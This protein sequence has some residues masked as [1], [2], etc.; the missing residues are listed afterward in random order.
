MYATKVCIR[1]VN[2]ECSFSRNHNTIKVKKKKPSA[3]VEPRGFG[4]ETL[5]DQEK[6][7]EKR[8]WS[9]DRVHK[10]QLVGFVRKR[11]RV[12]NGREECLEHC[13][14]EE[15]FIFRI[16]CFGQEQASSWH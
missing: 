3:S 16:N 4:T 8:S 11:F 7:T 14:L 13:L 2:E 6:Y 12:K 9:F 1:N 10:H 5:G 15:K